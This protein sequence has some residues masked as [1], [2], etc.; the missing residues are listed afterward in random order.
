MI[1]ICITIK[2]RSRIQV[3]E[4]ELLL[5]PNCVRSIVE[6][7]PVGLETELVVSDFD[8]DD[9]PLHEWLPDAVEDLPLTMVR[10][11]GKFSRG[12]G[13][14]VAARAARGDAL[15]FLDADILL[16]KAVLV[17]G[18]EH[19]RAGR[20]YFPVIYSYEDPEHSTGSWCR[21]GY[22]NC[23]VSR[24]HFTAAGEWPEYPKWGGEDDDFH[25]SIRALTEVVREDVPGF[26]HQWH[27][28]EILWKDRYADRHPE[29]LEELR[30]V[31]ETCRELDHLL[32]ADARFIL[33]DEG[34]FGRQQKVLKRARPFLEIDGMFYGGPPADGE[35]AV[36][37]LEKMRHE[38]AQYV[39]IT[40]I[41]A[42]WMDY[43]AELR[44]YLAQNGR[45]I[46]D[47]ERVR[48]IE[49]RARSTP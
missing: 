20:A 49:L 23:M 5:F 48:L 17:R 35:I 19:V 25:A 26:F 31:A 3:G 38:G 28:D 10:A 41:A 22:G 40:W 15:L 44:D 9:W 18:S 7:R 11:E 8:S 32:P 39:A 46:L 36:R 47:N 45:V 43:Y 14:N 24:Q 21:P 4:R 37:E 13:L 34:R 1:S 30:R 2:N 6:A 27:P 33:L 29:E 12:R 42:W 16:A